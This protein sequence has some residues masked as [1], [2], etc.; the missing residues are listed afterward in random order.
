MDAERNVSHIGFNSK[1]SELHAAAGLAQL[2]R[3]DSVVSNRK[4]LQD[5]ILD[6][7]RKYRST[8]FANDERL[9]SYKNFYRYVAQPLTVKCSNA[10]VKA[11][12]QEAMRESGIATRPQ[13]YFLMHKS[14]LFDRN[15]APHDLAEDLEVTEDLHANLLPLPSH[16]F[17]SE[18]L[19]TILDSA[20]Q[21]VE[22]EY[23][24]ELCR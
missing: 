21:S 22:R 18:Q 2:G 19:L 5:Q 12:I 23:E 6:I 20:L 24:A 1:M 10:T 15:S 9:T 14:V 8:L 3:I 13:T 17:I 16:S 7:V 4:K 11:K